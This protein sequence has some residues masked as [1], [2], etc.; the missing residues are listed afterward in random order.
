MV[1]P[2][3]SKQKETFKPFSFWS[4]VILQNGLNSEMWPHEINLIFIFKNNN[5]DVL[6]SKQQCVIILVSNTASDQLQFLIL[7]SLQGPIYWA[8][9]YLLNVY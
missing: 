7:T 6:L 8:L 9:E 2:Y 5:I 1:F 4:V 3:P